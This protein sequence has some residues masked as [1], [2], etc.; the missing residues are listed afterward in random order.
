MDKRAQI[1]DTMTWVVA[2]LIIVIVLGISITLS[3]L[4]SGISFK[5][6]YLV[7]K[8]KDFLATK[9]IMGFL[10]NDDNVKLLEGGDNEKIENKMSNFLQKISGGET[11]NPGGWNLEIEKDDKKVN[12]DTYRVVGFYSKFDINKNSDKIKLHFWKECQDGCIK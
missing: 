4:L 1:A 2:T 10:R 12:I 8:E 6:A 3:A 5:S 7:D 9:S 11:T